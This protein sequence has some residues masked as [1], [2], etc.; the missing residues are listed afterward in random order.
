MLRICCP[1]CGV[2]DEPEFSYGG[3]THITRPPLDC[4]DVTWTSYLCGRWFNMARDTVT[5]EVLAIYRVGEPKPAVSGAA[6]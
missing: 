3:P 1:Y 4:D 2:R 6:P 5:H